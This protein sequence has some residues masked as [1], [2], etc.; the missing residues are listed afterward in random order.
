MDARA[1]LRLFEPACDQGPQPKQPDRERLVTRVAYAARSAGGRLC[2][3]IDAT[4]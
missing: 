4:R 2:G 3:L 1:S